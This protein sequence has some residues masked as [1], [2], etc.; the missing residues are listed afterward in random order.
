MGID[1]PLLTCA[2]CLRSWRYAFSV[3]KWREYLPYGVDGVEGVSK[4]SAIKD[5]VMRA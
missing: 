5:H 3:G 4:A 1:E 2:G